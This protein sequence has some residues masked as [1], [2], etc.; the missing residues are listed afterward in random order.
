MIRTYSKLCQLGTIEERFRYLQVAGQVGLATFGFE[1]WINQRFY[2]SHQWRQVRQAVI[3]RDR[4]C[5]LG[6]EGYEITRQIAV[7]HMNPMRVN[8]LVHANEDILDPEFLISV[9]HLTHNAI[10]YG[11]ISLLPKPHVER[12]PGD[13]KLW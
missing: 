2:A 1:R 10:H 13:T 8:D 6:V 9:S 4:G 3:A 12:R 5:E 7:H 11:D